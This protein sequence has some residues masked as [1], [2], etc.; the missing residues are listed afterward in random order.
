MINVT[1]LIHFWISASIALDIHILWSCEIFSV[2][3]KS[4]TDTSE[5][6]KTLRASF[7]CKFSWCKPC[8]RLFICSVLMLQVETLCF[9]YRFSRFIVPL[10]ATKPKY[11]EEFKDQCYKYLWQ[12]INIKMSCQE[13][14][15]GK[16]CSLIWKEGS[17]QT[18]AFS[19]ELSKWDLY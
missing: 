14:K 15:S 6:N 2:T 1:W 8:S 16:K 4:V 13:N 9:D 3:C 19:F 10:Y 17:V 11:C 7:V 5:R 18:L 12:I